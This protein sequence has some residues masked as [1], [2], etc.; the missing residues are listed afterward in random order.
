ME[1]KIYKFLVFIDGAEQIHLY[2]LIRHRFY[3]DKSIFF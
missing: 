3:I 2:Q 1:Q